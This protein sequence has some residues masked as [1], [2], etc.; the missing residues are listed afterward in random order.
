MLFHYCTKT[1]YLWPNC[2]FWNHCQTK[3]NLVIKMISIPE[4]EHS[5]TNTWITLMWKI[6][7]SRN[8][9]R[10][11][12]R[13]TIIN[14]F[15]IGSTKKP[16]LVL[17]IIRQYRASRK[18]KNSHHSKLEKRSVQLARELLSAYRQLSIALSGRGYHFIVLFHFRWHNQHGKLTWG[19]FTIAR[20][21]KCLQMV[22]SGWES[23]CDQV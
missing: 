2:G 7:N 19:N 14:P 4:R 9:S 20:K 23:R 1:K 16:M 22:E 10:S 18:N 5:P 17:I 13:F 15:F 11:S 21:V 8:G 6:I 3:P 12:R